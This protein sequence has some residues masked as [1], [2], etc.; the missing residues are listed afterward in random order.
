[1]N[2]D[3]SK[4]EYYFNREL[5]WLK[6]NLRVLKEGG[7]KTTPLME[8]LKF[9]AIS[10]S[11]LDEF[12]MV[13]VAGLYDQF[14][15]GINKKDAAGLSVEE[16]LEKISKSAHT[17]MKLKYRYFFSLLKEMRNYGLHIRYVHE[18]DAKG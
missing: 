11:N 9:L 16:Q 18:V 4:P 17:Q 2:I 13:R 6:F 15:N 14:E 7:V 10:A 8:R 1:M 3:L 5:S 12:F